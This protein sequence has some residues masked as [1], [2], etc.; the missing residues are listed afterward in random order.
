LTPVLE[1]PRARRHKEERPGT[2]SRSASWAVRHAAE[3]WGGRTGGELTN[4]DLCRCAGEPLSTALVLRVGALRYCL[5]PARTAVRHGRASMP[6]GSPARARSRGRC[7]GETCLTF[8]SSRLDGADAVPILGGRQVDGVLA[9]DLTP[10]TRLGPYA[11]LEPLGT[12]GMGEVHRRQG[13]APP[14]R[15]H[16]QGAARPHGCRSA[17]SSAVRSRKAGPAMVG[18]WSWP[19]RRALPTDAEG[20]AKL[21]LSTPR[22]DVRRS[23]VLSSLCFREIAWHDRS[24]LLAIG[25]ST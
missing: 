21:S 20:N 5:A 4:L 9:G 25:G 10:S 11:I 14:S 22:A 1:R 7:G 18:A 24:H 6:Q 12:G 17:R 8:R 19:V 13:H 3:P 2:A 16:E 15:C 23:D